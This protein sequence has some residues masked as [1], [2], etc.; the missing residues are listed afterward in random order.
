M[1][2]PSGLRS[3]ARL[4]VLLLGATIAMS[5]AEA[6]RAGRATLDLV[7][8]DHGEL[9][10]VELRLGNAADTQRARRTITDMLGRVRAPTGDAAGVLRAPDGFRPGGRRPLFTLDLALV[11]AGRIVL[12]ESLAC[13]RWVADVAICHAQCDGGQIALE[14]RDGGGFAVTFGRLPKDLGEHLEP[15]YRMAACSGGPDQA[16][17]PARA[18]SATIGLVPR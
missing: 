17:T 7:P 15:G 6:Q 2:R 16:L 1:R 14:R 18:P 12:D 5:P 4:A 9:A 11:A 10:R 3:P 8:A 13:E